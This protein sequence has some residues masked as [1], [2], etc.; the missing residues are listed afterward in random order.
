MADETVPDDPGADWKLPSLY[1]MSLSEVD[2]FISTRERVT[3]VDGR[4]DQFHKVLVRSISL[5]KKESG[6]YQGLQIMT[7]R[8]YM[9][10]IT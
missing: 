6:W 10:S 5:W 3:I 7:L 2:D 9:S 4:T 1:S 8:S